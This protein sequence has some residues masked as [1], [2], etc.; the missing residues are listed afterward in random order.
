VLGDIEEQV[1]CVV[2]TETASIEPDPARI[3][4]CEV[5][6]IRTQNGREL[7]RFQSLVD[8]ETPI[9]HE[10]LGVHRI[11]DEM[12]RGAPKFAQVAP[13]L[14]EFFRGAVLVAHNTAF[15]APV[16]NAE[17]ARAG[18][19]PLRVGAIDTIVLARR[20]YA[21]IPSYGLDGLIRFFELSVPDRHRALGDCEATL[22]IFWKCVE[23]LREL[24]QAKTILD[25]VELGRNR[26]LERVK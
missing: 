9:S 5:A 16:I 19:P 2:D 10:A 8:P 23:R 22:F 3:R 24:G 13:R 4:V 7:D 20:A 17:L 14:Q 21:G 26:R 11:S 18:L 6:A 12:V 1:F 15:D 25:L